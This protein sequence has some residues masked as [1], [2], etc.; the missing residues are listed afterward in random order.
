MVAR[1]FSSRQSRED[2]VFQSIVNIMLVIAGVIALFPLIFVVSASISEPNMVA[3]GQVYL[4]PKGI[5]FRGYELIFKSKWISIGYRNSLFYTIVGTF[6]N[7]AVT[8]A[9]A[10]GLSRKKLYGRSVL[11]FIMVFTMWFSGGMIPTF[12]IVDKLKLIDKPYT[13][14]ILGMVSV[15]NMLISRSFINSSIPEELQE[16]ARMDGSGDFG[17]F[18]RIVVPLSTPVLAVISMFYALGHWNSYFEG[19]I[20][21][22]IKEYQPLQ[23]FLREVLVQNQSLTFD[24]KD[25]RQIES[26]VERAQTAQVMK[27]GLCVVASVPMLLLY[28]FVQRFFV[29]GVMIGALKG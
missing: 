12:V 14:L 15:Y 19:L 17:L 21:L 6:F 7:V 23:I 25:M 22:N 27:Y 5:Q 16:A 2:L 3:S 29:K 1:L 11:N 10:Y 9:A 13:L 20:Y 28:P 24:F 26:E 8:F 4:M 18:F